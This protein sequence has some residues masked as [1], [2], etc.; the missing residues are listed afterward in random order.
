MKFIAK[1]KKLSLHM[2]DDM[3]AGFSPKFHLYVSDVH[4][5]T[6]FAFKFEN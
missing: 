3:A 5:V 2:F 4:I 6:D 1:K